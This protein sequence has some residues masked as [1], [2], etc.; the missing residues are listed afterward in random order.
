MIKAVFLSTVYLGI[1]YIFT[2]SKWSIKIHQGKNKILKVAVFI[3]GTLFT[4]IGTMNL[5]NLVL[6]ILIFIKSVLYF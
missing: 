1:A 4:L 2:F 3:L 6:L 5:I